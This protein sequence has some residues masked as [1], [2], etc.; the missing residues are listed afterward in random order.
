M[1]LDVLVLAEKK[2]VLAING[3]VFIF[4]WGLLET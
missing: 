2:G 1:G 4:T 3:L